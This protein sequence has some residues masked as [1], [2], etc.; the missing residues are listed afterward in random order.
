M[1]EGGATPKVRNIMRALVLAL[2]TAFSATLSVKA[3]QVGPLHLCLRPPCEVKRLDVAEA[4]EKS[5]SPMYASPAACTAFRK[6]AANHV[7]ANQFE[8]FKAAF[9]KRGETVTNVI[10]VMIAFDRSAERWVKRNYQGGVA[11]FAKDCLSKMNRVLANSG[12]DGCFTFNLVASPVVDID[13]VEEYAAV[14]T[15]AA[16]DGYS[17]RLEYTDYNAALEDAAGVSAAGKKSAAWK[18]LRAER[19]LS[20]ADIVS[21]LVDSEMSGTVGLAY[22]L[23]DV[24]INYP[25]YMSD[26]AYCM[27][28]IGTTQKDSTQL[29]EI[30]HLMGAGH[31]DEMDTSVWPAD[32]LGPQLFSYSS[33]SYFD[34]SFPDDWP[35][36][37]YTVMGYNYPGP[38][39]VDKYGYVIYAEEEQCFSSPLLFAPNGVAKGS[40][41][42]DNART[43]RETYAMVA[44][45]RIHKTTLRVEAP[46]GGGTVSGSGAYSAGTKATLKAKPSA[47]YVFAGW[48]ASYDDAAG[49]FSDPLVGGAADYRA[50]TFTYVT[51]AE[52][53]IVYARF[54]SAGEDRNSIAAALSLP[55]EPAPRI[56]STDLPLRLSASCGVRVAW[57][58]EVQ[59]LTAPKVKVAGLPA[60]LKFAAKNIMKKGSKTEVDIPANTIY[61]APTAAS[62]V[63]K[64][65]GAVTPSMVKVTVTTAGKSSKTFL[66]SLTVDAMK[67]WAVGTFNGAVWNGGSSRPGSVEA[68]T[69]GGLCGLVTLTVAAN[70]KIGGKI[71]EGGQTWSLSAACFDAVESQA[72][73]VDGTVYFATVI[74]KCGKLFVTNEVELAA[75]SA[76]A[77]GTAIRGV[78]S[79]KLA[80]GAAV[81]WTAWQ[82]LWKTEPW[83]TL[84][85]P[86]AKAPQ[87]TMADG[88]T[89]K[90]AAAGA[91]AAK[92]QS[93]SCSSVLIPLGETLPSQQADSSFAIYLHFPPKAGKFNGYSREMRLEWDGS[94]FK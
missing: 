68:G 54:A 71:V 74:G 86:F 94:A 85:K 51:G 11:N 37:R 32:L 67:E 47:G 34:S 7:E 80:H 25:D 84:S 21:I 64:R 19:D 3:V 77:D 72:S 75:G 13:V 43:L 82:N 48:Y 49:A 29:H 69:D 30:G 4:M 20:C 39:W 88:V 5:V 93:N 24:S 38:S 57:P 60:G 91:V 12:L 66:I 73:N 16:G 79:C 52:S 62:K 10:D 44:N 59:A 28:C 35:D 90:F 70:G 53:A 89:L 63:D 33:S 81:A 14:D 50:A 76:V 87:L 2:C 6:L 22:A 56:L 40:S 92:Y 83:K 45:Y 27:A 65:T 58:V 41:A 23:D 42:H 78:A 61:G 26:V 36:W 18:A 15:Y 31:S 17:E 55:S 8:K 1:H 46:E 9:L